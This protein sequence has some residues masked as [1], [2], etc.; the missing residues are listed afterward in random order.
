MPRPHRGKPA[1]PKTT[2][3]RS[4]AS[5]SPSS[6]AFAPAAGESAAPTLFPPGDCHAVLPAS[7]SFHDVTF[8]EFKRL[9]RTIDDLPH[10]VVLVEIER[11]KLA[12]RYGKSL[13]LVQGDIARISPMTHHMASSL[14]LAGG[15]PASRS[16]DRTVGDLNEGLFLDVEV[17]DVYQ[18]I[19]DGKVG[20]GRKHPGRTAL[21]LTDEQKSDLLGNFPVVTRVRVEGKDVLVRLHAAPADAGTPL[22]TQYD[23]ASAS[24]FLRHPFVEA[25]DGSLLRVSLSAAQLKSLGDS[26]EA[27]V[28]IGSRKVRLRAGGRAGADRTVRYEAARY[29]SRASDRQLDDAED[30]DRNH[31]PATGGGGSAPPPPSGRAPP[32]PPS[33]PPPPPSANHP[34]PPPPPNS[35][36]GSGGGTGTGPGQTRLPLALYIPWRHRWVLKGYSRGELLHSLALGPQEEVTLEI[37]TWDRRKRSFEDSAS[38]E[39]EQGSEFTDTSKDAQSVVREVSN[40]AELGLTVNADVG[41]KFEVVNFNSSSTAQAKAALANSSKNNLEILRERVRKASS[42]LKLQRETKV[43]ESSEY[44]TENKVL[45]KVRNPNMCHT[46]TLNYYEVLAHYE[47]VTEFNRDEARLCVLDRNPIQLEQFG[48]MNVRYYESV[49]RR[50]LL[51]PDLSPGFDAAR[52]LFAQDQLGE[53]RRRVKLGAAVP[54][55]SNLPAE[56]GAALEGHASRAAAAFRNL[57]AATLNARMVVSPWMLISPW[58]VFTLSVLNRT[59]VQRYMYLRRARAIAPQL[60]TVLG[61]ITGDA[62]SQSVQDLAEALSATTLSTIATSAISQEKDAMYRAL[63]E[64]LAVPPMAVFTDVPDDVYAVDDA[65]LVSMLMTFSEGVQGAAKDAELAT[66]RQTMASHQ[67]SVEAEY[68]TKEIAEALEAVE[69]LCNHLNKY[70]NY[71]RTCILTLMPFPDEFQ[72]RLSLLPMIERRVLGFDNDEVAL[73][74]NAALDPRTDQLFRTLV[75]ENAELVSVQTTQTVMLPTSGIHVEARVGQCCA[76]EDYI[77]DLRD[78]D[79]RSREADVA[80]KREAAAEKRLEV[81]RR[82]AM[83]DAGQLEDPVA[84]PPVLRIEANVTPGTPSTPVTPADPPR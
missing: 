33:R 30:G 16:L 10:P 56:A 14:Q 70:R 62:S 26:G 83:L 71:Y 48:Y 11:E 25:V 2:A 76:C 65:G 8:A 67:S 60:F 59:E 6:P 39:F 73:S 79:L 40:Q 84:Q 82:R 27:T 69:S 74:V 49:L 32:P 35:G 23:V 44:G 81:E 52:K 42:K 1:A 3:E 18:V 47:I 22:K 29:G 36:P 57:S 31:P 38:S 34:P 58:P 43:S 64:D 51:V 53:A 46:L 78:L 50:V 61:S 20:L 80:L 15:V 5:H 68:S 12:E 9:Q 21:S 63:R 7:G 66:A 4:A 41:A 17:K 24:D 19:N 55:V 54:A 75:T 45:R 37:S 72:A 77:D 28:N 13:S